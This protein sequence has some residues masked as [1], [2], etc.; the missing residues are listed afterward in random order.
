MPDLFGNKD[1]QLIIKSPSQ[2]IELAEPLT[3]LY[4]S[5]PIRTAKNEK[6]EEVWVVI[7]VMAA[8]GYK[9]PKHYWVVTK[10]RM[11]EEG[12]EWVTNCDI[13]KIKAADG[14]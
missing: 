4:N 3:R 1:R 9:N 13:L 8:M 2:S 14:K 6:G 12:C 11:I 7:D 10:K 5:N